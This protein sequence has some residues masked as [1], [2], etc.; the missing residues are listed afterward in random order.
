MSQ[1]SDREICSL[2]MDGK[3]LTVLKLTQRSI[4]VDPRLVL[5]LKYVLM[6]D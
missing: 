2:K 3:I 4:G 6:T 1:T 5:I